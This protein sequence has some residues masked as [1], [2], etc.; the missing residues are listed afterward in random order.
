MDELYAVYLRAAFYAA[1]SLAAFFVITVLSWRSNAYFGRRFLSWCRD[2]PARRRAR[3][4]PAFRREREIAASDAVRLEE[5]EAMNAWLLNSREKCVRSGSLADKCGEKAPDGLGT[6]LAVRRYD[7][8]RVD[9]EKRRDVVA[10]YFAALPD[11]DIGAIARGIRA[12]VYGDRV[13]FEDLRV[14]LRQERDL[15]RRSPYMADTHWARLVRRFSGCCPSRGEE[16]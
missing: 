10:E 16:D 2:L 3:L 11:D 12:N 15:I 4:D 7:E 5:Y 13:R 8:A 9:H 1:V 6:G 14:F